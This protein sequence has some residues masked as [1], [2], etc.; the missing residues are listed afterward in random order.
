M[1]C[2]MNVILV[3][4]LT[5]V[6][7]QNVSA[8]LD[9]DVIADFVKNKTLQFVVVYS[10]FVSKKG[11]N[12]IVKMILCTCNE[13]I[14]AQMSLY[15]HVMSKDGRIVLFNNRNLNEAEDFLHGITSRT[16]IVADAECDTVQKLL[17]KVKQQNF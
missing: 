1:G 12:I 5:L 16:V 6:L 3:L 17:L 2:G 8:L 9:A 10:C 13:K 14:S 11:T 15:K 7:L 4:C